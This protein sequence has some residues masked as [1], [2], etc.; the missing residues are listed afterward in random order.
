MNRANV[1]LVTK[2]GGVEPIVLYYRF[3]Q[4]EHE[5]VPFREAL[6]A[7]L[8][9]GDITPAG[10]ASWIKERF[11]NSAVPAKAET[12]THPVLYYDQNGFRVAYSILFDVEHHEAIVWHWERRIFRGSYSELAQWLTHQQA[13][14][15]PQLADG[16]R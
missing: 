1:N 12:L 7:L 4:D 13:D 6:A 16:S 2:R 10:F 9:P 14:T 8:T 3:V 11:S 15:A 5:A